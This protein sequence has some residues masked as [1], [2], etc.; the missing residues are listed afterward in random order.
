MPGIS[1]VPGTFV[2]RPH[3]N[4]P[5]WPTEATGE[6]ALIL[7]LGATHVVAQRGEVRR[8]AATDCIG[9]DR[10]LTPRLCSGIV[11]NMLQ[12]A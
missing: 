3:P 7:P 5:P 10:M 2:E 1:E 8:G 11:H 4:P 9:E 6:G 12:L